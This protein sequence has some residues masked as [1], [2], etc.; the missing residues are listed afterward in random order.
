MEIYPRACSKFWGIMGVSRQEHE[1][2]FKADHFGCQAELT[3][4]ELSTIMCQIE[5]CLNS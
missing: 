5:A 2:S 1:N 4:E 3:F